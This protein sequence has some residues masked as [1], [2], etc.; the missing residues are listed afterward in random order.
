MDRGARGDGFACSPYRHIRDPRGGIEKSY[1]FVDL[2]ISGVD[3]N[4]EAR[5]DIRRNSAG[6]QVKDD[7]PGS[8]YTNDIVFSELRIKRI[9]P[10]NPNTGTQLEYKRYPI[11]SLDDPVVQVAMEYFSTNRPTSLT[12][13]NRP[14]IEYR[15]KVC[16]IIIPDKEPI[17]IKN[18]EV[19]HDV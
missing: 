13:T 3:Y 10:G 15:N 7:P 1:S 5:R 11:N 12:L 4:L 8:G 9:L 16:R 18:Y 19:I 6:L 14:P 17:E 2:R